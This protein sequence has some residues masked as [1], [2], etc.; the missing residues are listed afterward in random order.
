M[1]KRAFT[2]VELLIVVSI[3]GIMAA[4]MVPYFRDHVNNAKENTAKENLRLLRSAIQ[5]YAAQ[6]NDSPPGYDQGNK[7]APNH[8]AF[9]LQLC[10]TSNKSS[11]TSVTRLPGYDFGP[12]LSTYPRN[13]FNNNWVILMLGDDENFPQTAPN[14]YAYIYKPSTRQIRIDYPG[15]DS[16]GV[17]YYDY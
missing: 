2:I 14:L 15:K 17:R 12:Y 1:A 5:L 13:I 4:I 7:D 9:I 11:Q 16:E 3:L 6:H 8:V 10:L